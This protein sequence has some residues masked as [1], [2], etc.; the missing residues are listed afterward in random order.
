MSEL[1]EEIIRQIT[2]DPIKGAAT[3]CDLQD[4]LTAAQATIDDLKW[5]AEK[6]AVHYLKFDEYHGAALAKITELK[7][8]LITIAAAS[9]IGDGTTAIHK[10]GKFYSCQAYATAALKEGES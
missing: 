6:D 7:A 1:R 9:H 3:L 5:R 2:D 4:E 10:D 8:V